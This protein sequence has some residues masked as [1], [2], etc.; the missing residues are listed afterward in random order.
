VTAPIAFSK[1]SS[2]QQ[3][4]KTAP[5]WVRP[6]DQQRIAAYQIYREIYWSHIATEYKLMNRGLDGEDQPL[7]VPSSRIVVDTLDRYVG[8]KLTFQVDT[9]TGS[10]STQLLATETFRAFFAR[11]RFNSRYAA[12]KQDGIIT[13]DWGWHITADPT[14][15]EGSRIS[16]TP[17]KAE[18]YFPVYED[19][20]VQGGDPEKLVMVILAEQTQIGDDLLVRTQRYMRDPNGVILSSVE[21]WKPDEWF[22]WG[23]A[24]DEKEPVLVVIPPTPLPAGITQFPVYHVPHRPEVGEVFGVS[25]M[26]GL[27]VLQAGLNQGMT[28]ED[29]ALA[30]TGL[31]V[32]ATDQAGSP[33]DA[34]G[35]VVAWSIYPGAVIENSKGLRK[36]EGLTSLQPYTEHLGR[37]EGYMADATGATDAARGRIEVTEAESG[38]ALQL[39][40]G[41][42]LALAEKQDQIILDVHAQL[43]YDLT[44]M[45]FPEF[46]SLNFTDVTVMPLLGD[47]L[48]VNRK[49]E[50]DMVNSLVLT[51]ILSQASARQYLQTKGFAN[52]FDPREGDLVLAELSGEATAAAPDNTLEDRAAQEA[53]GANPGDGGLDTTDPLGTNQ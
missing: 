46:E 1:W 6:E 44:Q 14:K 16:L 27:E 33:R 32:Y 47:K 21:L 8:P 48:P 9:A 12:N 18:S 3:F 50:V 35:N 37:L 41:P 13:G 24:D 39:R 23:W 31:G 4:V 11:E 26:R 43:F 28:D 36:V 42:T 29:L 5:S 15:P 30:L 52:M 45:W 19:A 22:L 7:Y 51:H 53:A 38:I 20:T 10:E 2:V 49:G 34:G 17:F 40:L 25:P